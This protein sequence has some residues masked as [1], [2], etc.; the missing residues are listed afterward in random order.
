MSLFEK[1]ELG[2]VTPTKVVNS[3]FYLPDLCSITAL[4]PLI[5]VGQLIVL[6]MAVA[7]STLP[8]FDW[9]RFSLLSAETLW[10]VLIGAALLCRLRPLLQRMS[11]ASGVALC[12]TT[13]LL[14][15]TLVAIAGQWLLSYLTFDWYS[16]IW[17]VIQHIAVGGILA[18]LVLRYFYLQQQLHIQ[19]QAQMQ[20]TMQARFQSLQ[21]RIRPHFLFNSMNIVA[22][23]IDSD[24][25]TA[26]RVVEDMSAL[27]RAS[28][29]DEEDLVPLAQEISLCER[30]INIEQLRLGD[31][32][33]VNWQKNLQ[34]DQTIVPSLCLQPLIE[35]AIYH[36]I[37]PLVD[38][39]T[40]DIQLSDKNDQLHCTICNP[41]TQDTANLNRNKGNGMA[42]D[43]LE[44]RLYARYGDAAVFNLERDSQQFIVRFTI[45]L[46]A[47]TTE[48]GSSV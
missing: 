47:G 17:S 28:L 35:N 15:I 5:L 44:Q 40:I 19:Q 21:S 30:Y 6:A 26:E 31:R 2:R 33:R 46:E 13:L 12:F 27:F 24:P 1:K 39:G 32:L 7:A 4:L 38:G 18:G 37:Q 48:Q 43:N 36:G 20:A 8:N 42:L 14:V 29:S 9:L 41:Y 10:I 23:L 45:P 25:E 16:S 22:S 3:H 11:A 34:N